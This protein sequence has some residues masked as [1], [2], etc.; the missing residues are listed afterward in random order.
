[1]FD[2]FLVLRMESMNF[3]KGFWK[4]VLSGTDGRDYVSWTNE[5][6]PFTCR[7]IVEYRR[8][9]CLSMEYSI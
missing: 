4:A 5:V 2:E 6:D 7:V 8:F 9:S 1:M 3:I